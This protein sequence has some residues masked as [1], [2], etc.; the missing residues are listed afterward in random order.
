M[1]A[2]RSGALVGAGGALVLGPV[3]AVIA[4]VAVVPRP[5]A[6]AAGVGLRAGTVPAAYA[7]AVSRAGASCPALSAPVL[8]AQIET[9][10]GWNPAAVSPKGAEGLGQFLPG[11]WATMGVDAN[12]DGTADPFDP[13]DAIGAAARYD[14]Q[15]SAAVA[16]IPGDRTA[17]MLAAYNAG[18]GAVLVARGIPRIA[19]TQAYIR[20]IPVLAA[21]YAAPLVTA[22]GKAGSV[23]AAG[24][25]V[26]G[27]P[28][29]WG[30]GG[31]AGPTTGSGRGSG[32]VG[33]D[34]SGL[35]VWEFSTVGIALPRTAADQEAA[36]RPTLTPRPGDL[37]FFDLPTAGHVGLYLGNGQMLD[38]PH[39]GAVVRVEQV[40]GGARYGQVLP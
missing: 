10:S 38:A 34:C 36:T 37:V 12:N 11:T 30:G 26:L 21:S 13:L 6:A 24:M 15:V 27:T 28:Y 16:G 17:L 7:A 5:A 18:P 35:T 32:T 22:G 39:T 33:F 1:S 31:T 25:S 4:L 20:S 3:L 40:W 2:K 19:E 14:C 8:A 29:S 9:E 23:I